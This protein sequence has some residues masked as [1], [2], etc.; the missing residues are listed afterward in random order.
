[1]EGSLPENYNM[2]QKSTHK[3]VSAKSMAMK[4]AEEQEEDQSGYEPLNLENRSF[5]NSDNFDA[6]D[7]KF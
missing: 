7:L 1:M 2:L 6:T 4:K 5:L 3:R